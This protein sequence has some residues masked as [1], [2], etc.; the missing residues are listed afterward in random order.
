MSTDES[1]H[2]RVLG[3]IVSAGPVAA[4]DLADRLGL[5]PA[6]IRRHL[7][8]LIEAGHIVEHE[9]PGHH[10][11]GRG[12]PARAYV[13]TPEGQKALSSA[14]A[15]VAVDALDFLKASGG[16]QVFIAEQARR[17][18]GALGA[19]IDPTVP[20]SDR[21]DA[22]AAALTDRGY[23]ASV[24][25]LPGGFAIQLCQGH[26]PVQTVAEAA[27]EWCEAETQALSHI[28]GVHVQRLSTLA[29]GAHVCTTNIPLSVAGT[30]G[31]Q[32]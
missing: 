21:V 17:L 4:A 19:G 11:R 15:T 9:V 1:T 27:P 12:R 14:Y 18:E 2:E 29:G 31:A 32:P 26:C 16:L 20:L 7:T 30:K 23:S 24:R 10:D 28:L 25:P 8:H 13:A 5:T 22:L 6:G 3:L